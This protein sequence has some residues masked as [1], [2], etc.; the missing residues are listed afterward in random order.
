[1][2]KKRSVTEAIAIAGALLVWTPILFMAVTSYLN[3]VAYETLQIDYM[4]PAQLFPCAFIG[5]LFL[6]WASQRA[7]LEQ[8]QIAWGLGVAIAALVGALAV[9]ELSGLASGQADPSGPAFILVI[10]AFLMY[11]LALLWLCLIS[12]V[13]IKKL[14]TLK[15]NK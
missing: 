14:Y 13:L 2:E 8:R 4:I 15:W 11:L 6:K 1:M 7:Y 5:G 12:L 3:T 10:S 9:A